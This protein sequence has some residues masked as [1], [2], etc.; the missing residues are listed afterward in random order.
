MFGDNVPK[1]RADNAKEAARNCDALLVVGSAV[2]TMSA[3]RL[4]RY[5]L[6]Y[7]LISSLLLPIASYLV[8]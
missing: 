8:C 1:E 5:N 7:Y 4:A 6:K 2:M 3:F